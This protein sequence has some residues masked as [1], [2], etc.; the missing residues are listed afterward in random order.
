VTP[1]VEDRRYDTR[2]LVAALPA[3]QEAHDLG[4]ESDRTAWWRPG[5]ALTAWR[6]GR[7]PMLPPTSSTLALIAEH[8]DVGAVLA[9]VRGRTIVPLLP[10][11]YA[12]PDGEVAWHLVH[13][14][15]R[16]V[17]LAAGEPAGSET[18]G[19]SGGQP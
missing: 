10:H 19:A 15:T 1:E 17:V 6:E 9:A 14:R 12:G 3:S 8:H 5:D 16:A 7:M 13:E 18:D 11:P 4:G 2:F